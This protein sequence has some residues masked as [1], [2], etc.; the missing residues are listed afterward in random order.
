MRRRRLRKSRSPP[1]EGAL[2]GTIKENGERKLAT[3]LAFAAFLLRAKQIRVLFRKANFNPNQ[4]RVPSGHPHGGRWAD[5]GGHGDRRPPILLKR[6]AEIGVEQDE[7]E[8]DDK[9]FNRL[10]REMVAVEEEQ[11]TRWRSAASATQFYDHPNLQVRLNAAKATLAVAPAEARHQLEA[12]RS[13]KIYPQAADAGM[14]I[15]MLDSSVF[16]P[17]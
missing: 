17:E 12:I 2:F 5:D 1:G 8:F 11:I 15:R 4:P 13:S 9:K 6:Y 7:A 10:F 14:A 3:Q 16:K